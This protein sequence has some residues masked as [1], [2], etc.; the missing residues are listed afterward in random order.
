MFLKKIKKIFF[1]FFITLIFSTKYLYANES[2]EVIID[3]LGNL[4]MFTVSFVQDDGIDISEGKISIGKERVRVDYKQPSKIIIVLGKNKAM[5]YNQE[6]DEDEF[7]DPK[8]TPAHFFFNLFKDPKYFSDSKIKKEKNTIVLEKKT[9]VD[10]K[11]YNLK[12][13]FED[14][15]ILLRKVK[16]EYDDEFLV[17]SFYNYVYD[18]VFDRNF[19]KLINPSFFN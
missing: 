16:L 6:L 9:I 7:F 2:L 1:V 13:Y 10:L 17:L 14:N 8:D 19:F 3:Y 4:K 15:P 12:I 11:E 18:E 5:Y